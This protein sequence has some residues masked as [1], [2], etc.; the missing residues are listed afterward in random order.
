MSK[1]VLIVEDDDIITKLYEM[2]LAMK[3]EDF[4]VSHAGDGLEA[5]ASIERELPDL[6]LLDLRL[7]KADGF[8]VLK[9]LDERAYNFPVIVVTNYDKDEY[10]AQCKEYKMVLEYLLKRSIAID[11]LI[12]KIGQYLNAVPQLA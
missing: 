11:T 8:A 1:R 4:R 7:P 3:G 12:A 5:I 2:E 9:H 6:L 10:R